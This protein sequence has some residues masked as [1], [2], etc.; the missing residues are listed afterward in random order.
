MKTYKIASKLRMMYFNNVVC[1]E[2]I[3]LVA[4]QLHVAEDV[5]EEI[6][7]YEQGQQRAY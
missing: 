4:T 7:F 5:I 2:E 6:L 3:W 1:E